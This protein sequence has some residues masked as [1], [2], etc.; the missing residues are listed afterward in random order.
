MCLLSSLLVS[1]QAHQ[2]DLTK[3]YVRLK[4]LIENQ[5]QFYI[6]NPEED[7]YDLVGLE[8]NSLSHP[9]LRCSFITFI[10]LGHHTSSKHPFSSSLLHTLITKSLF[11]LWNAKGAVS[12]HLS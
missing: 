12:L 6:P 7:I 11:F 9:L 3:H 4:F 10:L 5:V 1:L 2:L 8:L